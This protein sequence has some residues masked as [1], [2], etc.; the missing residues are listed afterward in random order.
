MRKIV[1]KLVERF[2]QHLNSLRDPVLATNSTADVSSLI[3]RE[4]L[5]GVLDLSTRRVHKI[6]FRIVRISSDVAVPH[7]I[8]KIVVEADEFVRLDAVQVFR[9]FDFI[10]RYIG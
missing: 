3:S 2:K 9:N 1:H 7:V 8:G 10:L 4:G 6:S 5:D